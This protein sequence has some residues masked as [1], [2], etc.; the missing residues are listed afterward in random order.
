MQL[1][2]KL[3]KICDDVDGSMG[4][5]FCGFDGMVIG[6]HQSRNTDTDMEL[7]AANFA[8][9]IKNIKDVSD[10]IATFKSEIVAIKI[11]Q[12][13]FVGVVMSKDGN[14]GRLK[15]ELNKLGGDFLNG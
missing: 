4:A 14:L 5:F 2:S 10:I 13:G 9:V 8:S 11:S 12:D 6:M 7:V 1:E 15:L 3:K